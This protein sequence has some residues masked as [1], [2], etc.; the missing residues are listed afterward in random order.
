MRACVRERELACARESEGKRGRTNYREGNQGRPR[1]TDRDRRRPRETETERD[2]V[3]GRVRERGRERGVD[4]KKSF[5]QPTL[6]PNSL[7]CACLVLCPVPCAFSLK[8]TWSI[9]VKRVR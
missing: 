9:K 7:H 6:D 2:C 5:I 8:Y 1:K 3:R 4:R